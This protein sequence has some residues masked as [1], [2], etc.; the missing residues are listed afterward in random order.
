MP[1]DDVSIS[2]ERCRTEGAVE[3]VNVFTCTRQPSTT[4]P[5]QYIPYAS[6]IHLYTRFNLLHAIK[7]ARDDV[8]KS[9]ERCCTTAIFTRPCSHCGA[10]VACHIAFRVKQGLQYTPRQRMNC[11]CTE[12]TPGSTSYTL[13]RC[14]GIRR[15]RLFTYGRHGC[16]ET[17]YAF[18][19]VAVTARRWQDM[20]S[21]LH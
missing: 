18:P 20:M 3:V 19:A 15:P 8:S 4:L 7:I 1:Q 9:G 17:M 13:R 6:A 16:S 21:G 14:I 12:A 10:A 5:I 11:C 2:R